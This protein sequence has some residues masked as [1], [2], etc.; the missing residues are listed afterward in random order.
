MLRREGITG[1]RVRSE[2][3]HREQP[4]KVERMVQDPVAISSDTSK[5]F[6]QKL[7]TFPF[8]LETIPTTTLGEF[9]VPMGFTLRVKNAST[10]R[11]R[12]VSTPRI[13]ESIS[14]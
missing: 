7:M 3:W 2:V 10:L 14:V 9:P 12:G 13:Y 5:S 6:S 11:D 4:F 8:R 1:G